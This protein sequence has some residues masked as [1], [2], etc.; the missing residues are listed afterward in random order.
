MINVFTVTL[1]DNSVHSMVYELDYFRFLIAAKSLV[2]DQ[3]KALRTGD[4]KA[5]Q[6]C[7]ARERC[8]LDMV[9]KYE[10]WRAHYVK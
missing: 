1:A 7:K 8:L 2:E 4:K 3:R 6:A 5:I 9:S 10:A